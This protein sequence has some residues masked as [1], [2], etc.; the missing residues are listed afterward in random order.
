LTPEKAAEPAVAKAEPV[1]GNVE[2]AAAK[3]EPVFD[4]VGDRLAGFEIRMRHR[5]A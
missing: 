4:L 3:A 1:S 5:C 2:P